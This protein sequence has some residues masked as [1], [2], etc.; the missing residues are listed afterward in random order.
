MQFWLGAELETRDV[1]MRLVALERAKGGAAAHTVI[2]GGESFDGVRAITRMHIA[3]RNTR[4]L[5]PQTAQ[6]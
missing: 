1:A 5:Y 3:A 6:K 4:E 2:I